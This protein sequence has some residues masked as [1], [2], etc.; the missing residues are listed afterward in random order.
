MALYHLKFILRHFQRDRLF[1]LLNVLGLSLGISVACL[2]LLILHDSLTYDH[3][4]SKYDRIYRLG[5]HIYGSSVDFKRGTSARELSNILTTE[6]PEVEEVVRI[7]NWNHVLVKRIKEN[8]IIAFYEE[9]IINADS[10]YFKVFTHDFIWGNPITCLASKNS[11]VITESVA[12]K[13]F[14]ETLP[15]NPEFQIDSAS[16][17]VT[18]V[19]KDLPPNV[20]LKFDFIVS[21]LDERPWV[22]DQVMRGESISEAYWNPDVYTYLLLPANYNVGEFYDKFSRIS[23]QHIKPFGDQ[24]GG[25]YEPILESLDRIHFHSEL[26]DNETMGNLGYLYTLFG[27]GIFIILLACINFINLSTAQSIKR[28]KE[29]AI[30][31]TLGL[32]R[33]SLV[34][35]LLSESLLLTLFALV[36]AL[37]FIFIILNTNSIASFLGVTIDDLFIKNSIFWLGALSVTILIGI[38]SGL[39]PALLLTKVPAREGLKGNG[40][41]TQYSGAIL[42]K[43]LVGFQF[44][45][46]IVVIICTL[47]MKNQVDFLRNRNLGFDINH[48]LAIPIEDSNIKKKIESFKI[49]LTKLPSISKVTTTHDVIGKDPGK[50]VMIA[51]SETGM[52]QQKFTVLSAG[53]DYIKTLGLQLILGRDIQMKQPNQLKGRREFLVNE[54][55]V[56]IMGWEEPIGKKLKFF[57]DEEDGEVIGVVKDFNFTSL[58]NP[59]TPVAITRSWD[60]GG[61]LLIKYSGNPSIVIQYA[62]QLWNSYDSNYPFEYY[63]LDNQFN[64]QYQEDEKQY[65]QLNILSMI[66]ILISML[67]LLGLSAFAAAQRTKEIGIRKVLGATSASILYLL[68]QNVMIL[69][70]IALSLAVPVTMMIMNKWLSNFAYKADL[71]ATVFIVVA[72]V[73]LVTTFILVLFQSIGA[74]RTNPIE[75]LRSE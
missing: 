75:S 30:K 6:L 53:T 13:Y 60:D 35:T 61:E 40:L 29:I 22:K 68:Y 3:S 37:G 9:N 11:I 57:H 43:A 74:V 44:F 39:Y 49:E 32:Q 46:S 70:T 63:F 26:S 41:S 14:G 52:I 16:W 25:T 73:S 72:I 28:V 55:T 38:A 45:I 5:G 20:H 33:K 58:H 65:G 69:L 24:I 2:L 34:T 1:T 42:R 48:I 31:K 62:N 66:C 8:E 64:K 23:E 47:F 36:L 54:T 17:T 56:R 19:I 15:E 71:D 59:I 18:A 12:R 51:E 50:A 67:G 27:V 7:E 10:N 21:G 4:Y